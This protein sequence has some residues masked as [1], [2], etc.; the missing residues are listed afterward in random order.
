M[1]NRRTKLTHFPIRS[2][3]VSKHQKSLKKITKID[4]NPQKPVPNRPGGAKTT[5]EILG[6]A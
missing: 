4:K 6:H 1:Y 5:I 3:S 2:Q